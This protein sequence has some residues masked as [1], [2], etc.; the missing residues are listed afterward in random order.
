MRFVQALARRIPAAAAGNLALL[1]TLGA[2]T[3]SFVRFPLQ[4]AVGVG[5]L[6]ATTVWRTQVAR[7]ARDVAEC[8][9]R[10]WLRRFGISTVLAGTTWGGLAAAWLFVHGL[11]PDT[12]LVMVTTGGIVSAAAHV[13]APSLPVLRSFTLAVL[14]PSVVVLL[15]HNPTPAAL[16]LALVFVSY[17]SFVWVQGGHMHADFLN[18][19]VRAYRLEKQSFRLRD[20]REALRV[21]ATRDGL[22]G[23]LNRTAGLSALDLE[24]GRA[25]RD[26]K[27]VAVIMLDIDHFKRINDTHGHA[28]GDTVLRACSQ[29]LR[30]AL[31]PYDL[32]ARFG[33]EEFVIVLPGCDRFTGSAVAERLRVAL[34]AASIFYEATPIHVTSSFGVAVAQAGEAASQLVARADAALYGA[35]RDGRNRVAVASTD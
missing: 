17:A 9:T 2:L 8:E 28:A 7:A 35:K 5:A 29:R 6:A 10:R 34:D 19:Q 3:S 1:L 15:T 21:Q 20:S 4:S 25:R 32:I 12:V 24:L 14:A 11:D 30:A 26:A 23:A 13:S 22:T 31:R 33:G 27:H 16:G 18:A